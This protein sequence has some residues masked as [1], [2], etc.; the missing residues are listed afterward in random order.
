MNAIVHAWFWH[1]LHT[2]LMPT[3]ITV[4]SSSV[5]IHVIPSDRT[6]LA[7][8]SM[9]MASIGVSKRATGSRDAAAVNNLQLF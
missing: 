4:L 6:P 2:L 1:I 8:N 5:T 3:S 7:V 9:P